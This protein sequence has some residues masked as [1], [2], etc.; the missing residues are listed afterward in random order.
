MNIPVIFISS[1]GFLFH[2]RNQSQLHDV[3]SENITFRKYY[4]RFDNPF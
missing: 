2:I 4:L 1:V 3:E